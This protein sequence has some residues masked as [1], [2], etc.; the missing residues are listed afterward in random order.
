MKK[1]A[2]VCVVL[3]SVALFSCSND[4]TP[5]TERVVSFEENLTQ[6]ETSLVPEGGEQDGW[7]TKTSFRDNS[8]LVEIP[9]WYSAD[10]SFG[11]G[12]TYTNTTDVT[13]PGYV[14]ISAITGAG[15]FGKVYL[16][17]STN[18]YTPASIS[19][20]NTDKYQFKGA[21]VT[22]TTYAYLAIKD[23][24]DGGLNAVRQFA[25]GDYFILTAVG[26]DAQGT[27]IGRVN[28]YLADY[29]NGQSKIVNTWEWFDWSALASAASIS[30]ELDSTDKGEYGMNTPA[31]FCLD[32][33]T[34]I[35][36]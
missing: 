4:D 35:E 2:Y 34:L 5:K 13:T 29:R 32:G 3:L 15:K 27:E 20:L 18:S 17:S 22:N 31:Y 33:I 21:W 28:F 30:F 11:G 16:T 26:R 36:K 23:G 8:S 1:L 9:H 6:P 25:D 14:N 24:N 12:F 7:Y 19:I 10:K